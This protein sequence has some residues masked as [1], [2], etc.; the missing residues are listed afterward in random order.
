MKLRDA[1]YILDDEHSIPD[2]VKEAISQAL[3]WE[4]KEFRADFCDKPTR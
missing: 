1:H 2:I 3:Y 4:I